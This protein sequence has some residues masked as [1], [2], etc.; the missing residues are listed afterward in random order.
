MNVDKNSILLVEDSDD[1]IEIVSLHLTNAGYQVSAVSH[2]SQALQIIKEQHFDL[3]ILDILLPDST[4]Y[5]LCKKIRESIFCPIIFMSCLDSEEDIARAFELGGDGYIT[6]PVRPKEIVARVNA[7]L[8][9]VNQYTKLQ[10]Y[11][12]KVIE[13]GGLTLDTD[14]HVLSSP[15]NSISLTSLEF[16]ILIYLFQHEGRMISYSELFK[17][18]WKA[19]DLD[20]HRTVKVHMSN[21]KNKLKRID[22]DRDLISNIRGE[23]Y[24]LRV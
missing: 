12:G 3:I 5:E 7:N 1:I 24:M 17:N 8:R 19:E 14:K 9:R 11:F 6:K 22:A 18:V 2:Y 4:G 21:L 20:D 16:N 23:G 15:I 10:K 13:F